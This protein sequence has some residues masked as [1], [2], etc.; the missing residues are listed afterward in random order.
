MLPHPA[1]AKGAFAPL[2]V[3]A[4]DGS[5]RA[6]QGGG[7]VDALT[8]AVLHLCANADRRPARGMLRREGRT[9]VGLLR[10]T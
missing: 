3:R 2:G 1:A 8:T 6:H 5:A 10:W 4:S 9:P 7:N